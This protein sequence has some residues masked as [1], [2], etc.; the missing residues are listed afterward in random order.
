MLQQEHGVH[1]HLSG[2]DEKRER[3]CRGTREAPAGA[4]SGACY[5]CDGEVKEVD[6]PGQ[7]TAQR[8]TQL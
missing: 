2:V 5:H 7:Q 1:H 8:A 4:C 3:S 6:A